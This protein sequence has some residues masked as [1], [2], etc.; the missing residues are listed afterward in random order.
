M[1]T[2]KI[3]V[4]TLVMAGILLAGVN[5]LAY[6]S[7]AQDNVQASALEGHGA[8]YAGNGVSGNPVNTCMGT[9]ETASG[10]TTGPL[11]QAEKEALVYMVE[12]EKLA[13]DVYNF[14]AEKWSY[15]LF[16]NIARSEQIHMDAVSTLINRYGLT[17]PLSAQAGVFSNSDLQA[18]YTQLTQKG[19]LSLA[20]ALRAGGAI[21][22]LDIADLQSRLAGMTHSDIQQ[23]FNN[24]ML[25]SYNHLQAF[26]NVYETETGKVYTPQ[27]LSSEAFQVAIEATS[28]MYGMRGGNRG[29]YG[30]R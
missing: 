28:G 7:S 9:C 10:V 23:V 12:E 21:E 14:L 16:G 20:D 6:A 27:S 13:R 19:S 17:S 8:G 2:L 11:T 22:E 1:K 25:G 30:M 15:P 18:L 5:S 24:L 4:S 3:V 26:A 29:G